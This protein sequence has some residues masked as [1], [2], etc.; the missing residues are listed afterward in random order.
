MQPI[1]GEYSSYFYF[2]V[3]TKFDPFPVLATSRLVLRKLKRSDAAELFALRSDETVMKFIDRPKAL[4]VDEVEEFIGKINDA[5]DAGDSIL[6]AICLSDNPGKLIGTICIWQINRDHFRAE[7]GFMLHPDYWR[8]GI[9]KEALL[10]TI[11]FGFKKMKLHSIEGRINP[12]NTSSAAL[13]ESTGFVK[14]A[15]FKENTFYDGS[16]IDT[17]VY[18]RLR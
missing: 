16:F 5:V 15:H 11:D 4:S 9:M 8:K 18:S 1:V 14:E 2:M 6:W 17:A 7:T 3:V 13:L 10:A 12:A